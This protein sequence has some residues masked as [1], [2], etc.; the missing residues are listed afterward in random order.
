MKNKFVSMSGK[1]YEL[2]KD[3]VCVFRPAVYVLVEHNNKYLMIKNG[4][5]KRWEIP[6]GGINFG[7]QFKEAGIREIKEETGYDVVIE[8]DLPFFVE[9]DLAFDDKKKIFEHGLNF[10]FTAKLLN[11]DKSNLKLDE[12]ESILD[13]KFYELDE[14]LNLELVFWHK[15][16]LNKFLE[17]KK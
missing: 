13:Q 17:L 7:E 1:E 8:K 3:D 9:T 10:Y 15:N 2:T 11:E 12:E 6:G 16:A 5:S 4:L 14:L